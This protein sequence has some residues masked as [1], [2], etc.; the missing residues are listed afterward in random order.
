[1]S[2]TDILQFDSAMTQIQSQA[3]YAGSAIQTGGFG[4]GL[5][6]PTVMNKIL[7]QASFIA[8]GLANWMVG[9]G[10][11]VP[12]DGNMTNLV[13]EITLSL[14][15]FLN[16]GGAGPVGFFQIYS[17]NP[18]TH[19]AGSVGVSGISAPSIVWDPVD[20]ILWI[21]TT[22]GNAAAAVWTEIGESANWPFYGGTSTGTANAQIVTT[23]STVVAFGAGS[24][25]FFL[26]GAG[27]TNTSALAIQVGAFGTFPVVKDSPTGPIALIG[28]EVVAG[29][30]PFMKFDGTLLHLDATVLGTAAK[31]NASSNTGVV[32]AVTGSGSI[33]AGH[34]AVFSDTLGTVGDGGPAGV[35]PQWMYINSSQLLG[36]GA[37]LI[38]TSGGPVIVTT[39]ASP[40]NG[41]NYLFADFAETW[42]QNN[43]NINPNGKTIFGQPGI[44]GCN[45]VCPRAAPLSIG[46]KTSTANWGSN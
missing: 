25:F 35:A 6:D 19:V 45:I 39:E 21:C 7:H 41:D 30:Q 14:Q 13:N 3:A 1:M 18:N 23:P 38:D 24:S 10:I 12:D 5:V 8:A 22:T 26:V 29:T 28:G 27:L 44:L 42:P 11:S 9:Q 20:K 4:V 36:P 37:Y 31:A 40:T 34:L 32:A 16:G 43:F 46:Y 33:T 17:G 15:A 2:T